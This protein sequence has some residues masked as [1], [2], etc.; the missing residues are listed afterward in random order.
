M[1]QIKVVCSLTIWDRS[2]EELSVLFIFFS[3][4][5]PAV[6]QCD[7]SCSI[8][9]QLFLFDHGGLGVSKNTAKAWLWLKIKT[10]PV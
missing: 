5:N 9:L 6:H 4:A 8:E 10:R 1:P 2:S 3:R 7:F